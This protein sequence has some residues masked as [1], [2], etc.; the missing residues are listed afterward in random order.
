MVIEDIIIINR[1]YLAL[2]VLLKRHIMPQI[3]IS[4]HKNP[5]HGNL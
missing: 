5:G 1:V 4:A 3:K 2:F